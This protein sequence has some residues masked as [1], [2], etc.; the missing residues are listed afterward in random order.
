M[1]S[2][3]SWFAVLLI[4]LLVFTHNGNASVRL[5]GRVITHSGG[6][7][8]AAHV[9]LM[10]P[11]D[12]DSRVT[13]AVN[14]DG[15]YRLETTQSGFLELQFS[16]VAHS[17]KTLTL[18][19]DPSEKIKINMR[20]AAYPYHD[21]FDDI[22]IFGNFNDYSPFSAIV[23]NKAPDDSYFVKL[24]TD[25]PVVKYQYIGIHQQGRT[26]NGPNA[27]VYEYDGEGDYYSIVYNENQT[28][29]D[30][31]FDPNQLVRSDQAALW[32]IDSPIQSKI[33]E[34][35]SLAEREQTRWQEKWKTFQE[36]GGQIDR[37][38]F[39]D[40]NRQQKILKLINQEKNPRI[41]Q[42]L[43]LA[44]LRSENPNTDIAALSLRELPADSNLWSYIEG[45]ALIN[46]LLASSVW[47]KGYQ[48]KWS[49]HLNNTFR[50]YKEF[51]EQFL[52][53]QPN[54]VIKA[55]ILY[56]KFVS[57][58]RS[59]ERQKEEASYQRLLLEFPDNRW[60]R[61]LEKN[62]SPSGPILLGQSVPDFS[63]KPMGGSASVLSNASLLGSMYLIDFWA[64]W[65]GPCLKEMGYLHQ[66]FDAY[67][68]H[69][70]EIISFSMDDRIEDLYLFRE[71]KW[72][73]P[74]HHR[75][76][77]DGFDSQLAKVF[78]ITGLPTIMLVDQKG[79]IVAIDDG[80][81]GND[82]TSTLAEFFP[83]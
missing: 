6:V 62:F 42:A 12:A 10:R 64:S 43:I 34:Y 26:I 52:A 14:Q 38:K 54:T 5:E 1:P 57:A 19:L 60:T 35:F 82:L 58:A 67:S 7:A 45:R 69:G 9:Q 76:V 61:L 51:I 81:R 72:P 28:S 70:L 74:W 78:R 17:S 50:Q 75:F 18:I 79:M 32:Q 36:Q 29:V 23:L 8:A 65:C 59:G 13:V 68:R 22:S 11:G 37:F 20:L 16:A 46:A 33:V 39:S 3:N 66:A 73:M 53:E 27:Q 25:M 15:Y 31:R 49:V 41:R 2:T 80:L 40:A 24:T 55:P 48:S 44:A 56:Y 63:F 21:V 47:G 71:T 77:I 83:K 4:L 30:I